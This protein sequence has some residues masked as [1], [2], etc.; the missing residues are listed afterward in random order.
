MLERERMVADAILLERAERV[1]VRHRPEGSALP[2]AHARHASAEKLIRDKAR[3]LRLAAS[4][5]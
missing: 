5:V 2:E 1:L 3:E 4:N